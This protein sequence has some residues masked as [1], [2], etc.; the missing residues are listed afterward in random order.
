MQALR[1][2]FLV[3]GDQPRDQIALA[4]LHRLCAGIPRGAVDHNL[5]PGPGISGGLFID[6]GQNVVIRDNEIR[7]TE[8]VGLRTQI[9]GMWI[10]AQQGPITNFEITGNTCNDHLLHGILIEG[11]NA[12]DDV[13]VSYNAANGN[14]EYG[15]QIVERASGAILDVTVCANDLSGPLRREL[16]GHGLAKKTTKYRDCMII[17]VSPWVRRR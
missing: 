3:A 5:D 6:Q 17:T 11:L 13:K 16:Q 10:A 14:S 1:P 8:P 12:V 7:N 4:R 2:E 9:V 15:L